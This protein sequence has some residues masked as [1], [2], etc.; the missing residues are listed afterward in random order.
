VPSSGQADFSGRA[1]FRFLA[2]QN[3]LSQSETDL[4]KG[5][6][7]VAEHNGRF[8]QA[9][10]TDSHRWLADEPRAMGGDD[11]GP[12]PYEHLLAALGTCTAMTLRMYANHKQLPLERISVE[13]AH[14]R[15][16]AE[17]CEHCRDG[18][19]VLERRLTLAGSLTPEQ[20]QRLLEIAD[21]CPVHRTLQGGPRIE[22]SLADE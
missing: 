21:R 22:T 3:S 18:L 5:S 19:D 11:L 15:V 9:V 14:R 1:E 7:R 17:D 20:R 6:V 10:S 12:D 16:H 2:Q 13:L 4:G 8:A